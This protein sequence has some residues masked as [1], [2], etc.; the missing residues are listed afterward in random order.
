MIYAVSQESVTLL[1]LV[2][3]S[4]L[5]KP[6]KEPLG[7]EKEDKQNMK[8]I[9]DIAVGFRQEERWNSEVLCGLHGFEIKNC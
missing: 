5:N 8:L 3:K 7:F 9:L 6:C 4:L 2:M 1:T